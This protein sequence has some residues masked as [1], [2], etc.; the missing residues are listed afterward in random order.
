MHNSYTHKNVTFVTF[1]TDMLI[2][3][4]FVTYMQPIYTH[5]CSK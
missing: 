5:V 2:F 4:T 3:E 1:K